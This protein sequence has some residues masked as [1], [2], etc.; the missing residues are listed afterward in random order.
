MKTP[1]PKMIL[2]ILASDVYGDTC[3]NE[4]C[5]MDERV[6]STLS[7]LRELVLAK[8]KFKQNPTKEEANMMYGYHQALQDIAN[9]FG[10]KK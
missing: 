2:G 1:T 10:G 4:G 5:K 6:N 7:A 8:K 3:A 9:L